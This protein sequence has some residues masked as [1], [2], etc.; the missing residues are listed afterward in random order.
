MIDGARLTSILAERGLTQRQLAADLYMH[1]NTLN[2]YIKNHRSPD[3][4]T[5]RRIASYLDTSVDYLI[6]NSCLRTYPQVPLN[7]PEN[8]IVS[9]FRS[10]PPGGHNA[11]RADDLQNQYHQVYRVCI[12]RK[13][14]A[15]KVIVAHEFIDKTHHK[16][17]QT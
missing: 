12:K 14:R 13:I 9:Q 4:D 11:Y 8:R 16:H 10:L 15:I 6:G 7:E 17:S 2:G 3:C 1:P 5:I